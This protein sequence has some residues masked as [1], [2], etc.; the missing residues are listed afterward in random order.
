VPEE[1]QTSAASLI[2]SYGAVAVLGAGIS[3]PRFPLTAQLPPLVWH[4]ID[5]DPRARA[6][7][8]SEL[9]RPSGTAKAI[10]GSDP[11]RLAAA[12]RLIEANADIRSEFQHAFAQ[13][14]MDRDPTPAHYA[15]ARLVQAGLVE[16]VISLNWDT[17]LER[18]H[19]QLYGTSL[20][21]RDDVLAKPH[22]DAATR[23]Q[24]WIL[25]HQSGFV[26]AELVERMA[27]MKRERPRVLLI[28]GYSGSDPVVVE[29]LLQDT[30]GRWPVVRVSPDATEQLTLAGYADDVLPA[31]ADRLGAPSGL[32][33]WR[34]VNFSRSRDMGAALLGYRLGPQDV[35]SCPTLPAARRVTQRLRSTGFAA[36]HGDSGTGKSITAFQAAYERS[37]DGWAVVELSQPGVAT[38]ETVREF[39]ALRGPVLAV[40]DD[41]QALSADIRLDFGRATSVDHAVI[42]AATELTP[43]Q[44]QVRLSA[45]EATAAIAGFCL[46]QRGIVEPLVSSL[47]DRVGPGLMQEPFERRVEVAAGADYPWQFMYVLS[48]GDR[49]I[50]D[51]IA[52]LASEEDG[53]LL[54]GILATGQLTSLDAGMTK[55]LLVEHVQS[56]GRDE[57]WLAASLARLAGDRLLLERGGR[58]RTPHLRAANR[59]LLELCRTPARS[60]WHALLAF[61]RTRL[62]NR[63]E[64]LQGKLW[65]L[66]A[67]DQLDVL[68]YA[69][70][71]LVLDETIANAIVEGCL[72]APAGR[73]RNV[74]AYL[75]WEVGWWR[76]LTP[77]MAQQVAERLPVW[78]REI[79]SADVYGLAW[80]LGGLRSGFED[81]H[82]EVSRQVQ[83]EDVAV[84]LG[85]RA[86]SE[87]GEDWGRLISELAHAKGIDTP[88]WGL[89]FD[90]ATDADRVARR[91]VAASAGSSLRGS[92]ELVDD[93][94]WLAPRVAA[95]IVR[96][97]TPAMASRLESDIAGASRDLV[98]WA[99]SV[100]PIVG[101]EG[102]EPGDEARLEQVCD[103][104]RDLVTKTDWRKAGGGVARAHLTHLDQ[105]HPLTWS[106]HRL[107]PQAYAEL[108]S[109]VSLDELDQVTAG[110][111]RDF[112]LIQEIVLSLG[113][114]PNHEP[115]RTWVLRHQDEIELIPTSV[116]PIAPEVVVRMLARGLEVRLDVQGGLRWEWCADALAALRTVSRDAAL[117][118]ARSSREAISDGLE[119]RQANMTDELEIFVATLDEVDPGLLL[120]CIEDL[121]PSAARA[122]WS[123]RLAGSD[124]ERSA[125]LLLLRRAEH[126]QSPVGGL[127]REFLGR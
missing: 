61:M 74:A 55:D 92:V 80:L 35:H 19:E 16:Y 82:S 96:A 89:K 68:R 11:I 72:L 120:G 122:S 33:G 38:A 111:W 44:E 5:T 124:A 47:D 14:D 94:V 67:V 112:T 7:L 20:A 125:A 69:Q 37:H 29:Q 54:L 60:S 21:G 77:S 46:D 85:E 41:A 62:L 127:S 81:L 84:M 93:L 3:A 26:P 4:A 91:I 123:A 90:A 15:L 24:P 86:D 27:G 87:T 70:R 115:A 45:A 78:L 57:L 114:G 110:H 119:L 9:S 6:A 98:P 30:E 2:K 99:F 107:N 32:V 13:L 23:G 104:I 103:A 10:I 118:V 42:L 83:P 97:A 113:H 106:L 49:R 17:L 108:T 28:V 34:W 12:W 95:A 58:F 43:G 50:G 88:G 100:F 39:A 25:P 101:A 56:A 1:P 75:L 18:A 59:A 31:L 66:R 22:G 63:D 116:I 76:A 73:E 105:L 48:G 126:S 40:V 79:S 36:I 8:A 64:P 53:D 71:D 65:L 117:A 51:A 121:D 102:L 109:A 52:D